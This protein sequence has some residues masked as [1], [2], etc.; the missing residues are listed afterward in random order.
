MRRRQW[1][2]RTKAKLVLEGLRGWS[3]AEVCNAYQISRTQYYKWRD[4][5]LAHAHETF[6]AGRQSRR[7]ARLEQEN[8]ELKGLVGELTMELKKT[9]G[10]WR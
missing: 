1:D 7:E 2:G 3:L 10:G 5:F 9:D 4:Q 6:E 8:A